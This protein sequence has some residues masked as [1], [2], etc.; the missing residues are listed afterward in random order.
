VSE[1][2]TDGGREGRRPGKER[3]ERLGRPI[4]VRG[5]APTRLTCSTIEKTAV[6]GLPRG[7]EVRGDLAVVRGRLLLPASSNV[8]WFDYSAITG[9]PAGFE[10]GKKPRREK[11]EK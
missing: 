4:S 7:V 9:S 1:A 3:T 6:K 8:R 2:K 10:M 11:G 5:V